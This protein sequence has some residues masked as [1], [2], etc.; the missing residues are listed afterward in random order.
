MTREI[1]ACNRWLAG[2]LT[3][4]APEIVVALGATAVVGVFGK[5][6]PIG[7]NRGHAIDIDAKT[8]GFITAHPSYLLRVEDADKEREYVRF[9]EDLRKV[10]AL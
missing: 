2:E 10:A 1:R 3:A 7:A 5:A 4:I 9:V 6:M 8:R